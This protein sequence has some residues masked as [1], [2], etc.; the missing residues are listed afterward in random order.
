MMKKIVLPLLLTTCA[1]L[2]YASADKYDM[3][4]RASSSNHD[5]IK[6]GAQTVVTMKSTRGD[7]EYTYGNFAQE[8]VKPGGTLP[9]QATTTFTASRICGNGVTEFVM[10]LKSNSNDFADGS[11]MCERSLKISYNTM[12]ECT[13]IL[14]S[15][16][17][18]G[19]YT[20]EVSENSAGQL[21]C[22]GIV[23]TG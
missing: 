9:T 20:L 4:V 1:A 19:T 23:H 6:L 10:R 13:Q 15:T 21:S 8:D 7:R 12:A 16:F 2:S 14:K 5:T 3:V 18:P 11:K 22:S 17:T